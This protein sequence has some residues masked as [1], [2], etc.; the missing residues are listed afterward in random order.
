MTQFD[1]ARL[2]GWRLPDP[3]PALLN[4]NVALPPRASLGVCRTDLLDRASS[5]P[6]PIC[7]QIRPPKNGFV[8]LR[9]FCQSF[10]F[11]NMVASF[12]KNRHSFFCELHPSA[13]AVLRASRP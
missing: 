7:T 11:N 10:I 13:S 6:H 2:A 4:P 8:W 9:S 1:V 5:F 3:S 12:V